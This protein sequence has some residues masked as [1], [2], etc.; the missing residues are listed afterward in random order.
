MRILMLSQFYSPVVGGQERA[1]E[2]LSRALARRGHLV[3]V[4][5]LAVKGDAGCSQEG[6][7][8]VYR[9]RGAFQRVTSL[10]SEPDRPHVPPVP[11][12]SAL[13]ELRR[14][15]RLESPDVIHAHDWLIRS[16]VPILRRRPTPLIMSLHDHSLVCANKRLMSG[17]VPCSGPGM[18]KCLKCA[19]QQYGLVKGPPVAVAVRRLRPALSTTV[20]R[21]LPVSEAVARLSGLDRS[22]LPYEVV[23]N[24][25]P[26]VILRSSTDRVDRSG[27][28]PRDADYAVFVGDAT[29]DKGAEVLLKAHAR[30][31]ARPPLVFIGRPLVPE[32]RSPP[33]SVTVWG[34]K[35]H[36][37]VLEGLRRSMFAVVPSVCHE[38]FGLSA[39]EA[40]AVGRPVIASRTGG[41][42]D[43]VV[44]GT[45]ILTPPGDVDA[46]AQAMVLLRDDDRLR[47]EMGTLA[48]RRAE[49][50]GENAVVEKV[51]RIYEDVV[52]AGPGP[53]G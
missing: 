11:D 8:R 28:P 39:L 5:T 2:N 43:L 30:I 44:P 22:G 16:V 37:T 40:M 52:S 51:E 13:A 36:E 41:L 26:D 10:F 46:L 53:S 42:A 50:F 25:I 32:L 24:F 7:V 23:P 27:L 12:V 21:F 9:V 4:L 49:S 35:S 17:G 45:G 47:R 19:S 15:I 48:R 3:S 18:G 34:P 1:V 38:A 31:G 33:E 14:V 29:Q 6:D 20:S